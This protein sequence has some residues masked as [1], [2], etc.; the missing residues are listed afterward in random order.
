MNRF[1]KRDLILIAAL[2]F[3]CAV[4]YF[5]FRFGKPSGGDIV[6]SVDGDEY[7]RYR[8]SEAQTVEITDGEGCVTNVLVIEDGRARMEEADCPDQLCVHQRAIDR[9]G[10]T[11]VCLPN[12]VI[13]TVERGGEEALDGFVQ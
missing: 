1:G 13:A 11:I 8:L 6:V 9:A 10:E 5:A 2:F 12:R 3:I 7:G 4:V